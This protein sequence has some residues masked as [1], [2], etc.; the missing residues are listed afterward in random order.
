MSS[1][2]S[3]RAVA[4]L[5]LA[6]LA[7]Q[8]LER[9]AGAVPVPALQLD[10]PMSFQARR[11][12]GADEGGMQYRRRAMARRGPG[13]VSFSL[14]GY[15]PDGDYDRITREMGA[16]RVIWRCRRRALFFSRRRAV[17]PYGRQAVR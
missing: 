6:A 9:H 5:V 1:P 16:R 17:C 2:P 7:P 10:H 3:H 14:F 12:A 13:R 15:D 8:R 4:P 11:D